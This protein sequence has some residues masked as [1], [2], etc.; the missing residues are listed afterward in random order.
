MLYLYKARSFS[1]EMISG[2]REAKNEKELALG[3]KNE[4]LILTAAEIKGQ[5]KKSFLGSFSSLGIG[6]VSLVEKMMFTRNLKVMVSAG[7][8]LPRAIKILSEQTK[9]SKMKKALLAISEE[10]LQG[11]SLSEVLAK[12]PHIFSELFCSMIKVG[13]EAGTLEKVLGVLAMQMERSHELKSKIKGAMIYPMVIV[14]AMIMIAILMMIVVVPK[15]AQTFVDLNVSLPLT[16]RLVIGISNTLSKFWYLLP[17]IPILIFFTLRYI[18]A[19]QWGKAA[20]DS[21]VLRL[22]VISQI[23]KQTNAA[24]TTRNLSSLIASGVPIVSALEIVSRTLGNS[25]Y[26]KAIQDVADKVKKGSR[27]A[28]AL[29]PHIRIYPLVVIQMIAVGEETGQTSEILDKLASFFEEEVSNATRNLSA[30]IEPVLMLM[31]GVAVGFF[32]ISMMQ[33]LYSMLGA[34]Q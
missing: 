27:I 23:I 22:P 17:L 18:S 21:L 6:G 4:G 16:T 14:G 11:K 30:L 15:L 32:A 13:E 12:Y 25:H 26:R 31:V 5:S 3:L 19:T 29:E 34:I 24:Y 8:S 7:I 1:G 2:A 9:S 10:I 28:Q 20:I 33:P